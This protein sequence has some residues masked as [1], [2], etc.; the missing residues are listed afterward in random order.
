MVF[1]N[2]EEEEWEDYDEPLPNA[3]EIEID[4]MVM[5]YFKQADIEWEI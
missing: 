4:L 3:L 5:E 2:N 1:F